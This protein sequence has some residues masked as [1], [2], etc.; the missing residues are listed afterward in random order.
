[1]TEPRWLDA[2]AA[3]AYISVR[4]DE[5][6]RLRR[7]GKLPAPSCH[8]GPRKPRYDRLQLDA[9]FGG[10]TAST[11]VDSA[12]EGLLNDIAKGRTGGPQAAR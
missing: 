6:P 12:V 3:A 8:L 10:G 1:M 7:A 2:E 5:L 9:M 11:D 4:V